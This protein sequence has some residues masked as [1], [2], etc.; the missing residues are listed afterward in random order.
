MENKTE[1]NLEDMA[2]VAGGVNRVV[3]TGINNVNAAVRAKAMKNS[4]Q[5][6]SLPNG[7]IVNTISDTLIFDPVEKR[8]FV[9]IEFYDKNGVLRTGY[10]AAS[11]IGMKR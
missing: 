10:I 1:L 9:E 4:S 8:N 2:R 3:N 11:I 5:I 6:A 7:T